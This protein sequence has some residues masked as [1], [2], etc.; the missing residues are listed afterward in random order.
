MIIKGLNK[1]QL[2]FIQHYSRQH[3]NLSDK[4]QFKLTS[5]YK[6]LIGYEVARQF[7][8]T[9]LARYPAGNKEFNKHFGEASAFEEYRVK[10]LN[11]ELDE[12]LDSVFHQPK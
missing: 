6:S 1:N 8:Q 3:D 10:A 9:T 11:N 12:N 2:E 4:V 5:E 7:C